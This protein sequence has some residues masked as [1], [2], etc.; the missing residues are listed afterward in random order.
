M[1]HPFELITE[2]PL[3]A[4]PEQVWQAIA[5]GPGFDAW[6]MGRSE[7]EAHEGGKADLVMLGH[8]ESA[9]ITAYEPNQRFASRTEEGPDGQFMAFEYLIE[10]AKGGT[11]VLRIVHN[12]MLGDDWETEFEAMKA[13]SGIY[14]AT[15]VEYLAHF[16]GRSPSVVTVFRPGAADPDTAWKIL[17]TAL[18]LPASPAEGDTATLPGGEQGTVFYTNLPVNL[19][20]RTPFG[21]YRFIHSGA[22]RGNVVVQGHQRF[23][24]RDDQPLWDTWTTTLFP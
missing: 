21:L 6:F 18:A 11:S 19:G 10:A 1:T 3:E 15:L 8:R 24:G 23:D 9:T 4:T 12:G 14:H 16:F 13:G 7:I 22:D 17:T 2:L 20:I 5:T